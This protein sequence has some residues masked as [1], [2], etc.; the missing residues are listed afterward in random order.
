MLH[1]WLTTLL[2]PKDD[3]AALSVQLSHAGVSPRK[4][5]GEWGE[6]S[7]VPPPSLV[8]FQLLSPK[9]DGPPSPTSWRRAPTPQP[10]RLADADVAAFM[11]GAASSAAASSVA[12]TAGLDMPTEGSGEEAADAAAAL[13]PLASRLERPSRESLGGRRSSAVTSAASSRRSHVEAAVKC[14][15]AAAAPRPYNP[16]A[17]A[18]ILAAANPKKRPE[19]M[20]RMQQPPL[21]DPPTFPPPPPRHVPAKDAAADA[22]APTAP[23]VPALDA[24]A[25]SEA[26]A[27][28][29]R[30]PVRIP[31][32]SRRLKLSFVESL[33]ASLGSADGAPGE[34]LGE[35][36]RM[37]L[38]EDQKAWA[39]QLAKRSRQA[40]QFL[41]EARGERQ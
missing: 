17:A 10:T 13:R 4:G 15:E 40:A 34:G 7:G 21:P 5:A 29:R 41:L 18:A 26:D 14:A 24:T 12:A 6:G 19:T 20:W 32:P 16:A 37:A 30:P 27:P 2:P 25:P 23:A 38:M 9:G 31:P 22:G 35:A 36:E 1:P 8:P 39:Q 28:K 3:T 11:I 33:G